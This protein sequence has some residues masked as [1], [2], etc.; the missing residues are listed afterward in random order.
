MKRRVVITGIGIISALGKSPEEIRS[1]LLSERVVFERPDFD[2]EVVVSP[3]PD[4]DLRRYTGT[5]KERRYLTRG[6]A[7][8][9]AA[10]IEAVRAS[11]LGGEA[12]ADAGLFVGAGPHLDIGREFPNMTDG[13]MDRGKHDA[14]WILRFLPNTAASVI[15]KFCGIRGENLTVGT[16]CAASLVAIGE[17]YRRIRDGYLDCA[18][19]G[20]GDSRT[21]PGGIL[22]YKTAGALH[23]GAGKV[24]EASRPFDEARRGFVSGEGAAFFI[25]E[26]HEHAINR[27]ALIRGEISGYGCS[28]DGYRMTAP[29]PDGKKAGDAV[30]RAMEEARVQS[31]RIGFIAAHGTGTVLNDRAEAKIIRDLFPGNSP[32]VIALKSW[33]GHLSTACGAV[34]LGIALA[35]QEAGHLPKIR[36]LDHPCAEEI[37]FVR[38]GRH[39]QADA[40]LIEN[41][42]F[43][44]QN[45]ALVV[46]RSGY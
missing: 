34:E 26:E 22:A 3:V 12:L 13:R 30:R 33:I 38:T 8:A 5:F 4:F 10:A 35:A 18:L 17:A 20:G 40:F 14:L 45:A 9:L 7:F 41:F 25:L 37:D 16:A 29:A 15:A 28:I 19:A 31:E 6:A 44:G 27:G 36:N 11:G 42:G 21:Y 39:T 43:G 2:P 32:A 23:L 46:E 24:E 1:S